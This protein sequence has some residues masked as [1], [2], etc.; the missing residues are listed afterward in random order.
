MGKTLREKMADLPADRRA[1]IEADTRQLIEEELS[2][3]E[4][5]NKLNLTQAQLAEAL[6]VGQDEVSRTER[7]SDMLLSTL[8]HYV[9]AMGGT[10][11]LVAHLP[12]RPPVRITHFRDVVKTD[13]EDRATEA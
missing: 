6:G 2:L 3:R 4:L 9:Q 11:D 12:N 13:D 1:R 7:R 5:R 8:R 10:L